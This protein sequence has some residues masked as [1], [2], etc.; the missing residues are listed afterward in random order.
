MSAAGRQAMGPQVLR[1]HAVADTAALQQAAYRWIVDASAH[2]I[3]ARGSFLIVLA[4]GNTPRGVYAM[5]RD[6]T[7][8][9]SCWDVWFGDERCA[10]PDDP[11]RNSVM[12]RDTWLAH[13]AIP[14]DRIH[15]IPSEMGAEPASAAYS[16][17][18]RGIGEFDLVLLGLG[19][20]GHTASL[21]PDHDWGC[22]TDA[23][24]VLAILDASK[25]P[26]QRVSLSA[27]RLS[28]ACEVLFLVDGESK[29]DAVTR[30][31]AGAGIPASAIRPMGGVDALTEASLLA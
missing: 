8:D 9:W 4:G 15:A 19:E 29:R 11:E 20:D 25:P 12:A 13:V 2:A 27:A 31:R 23:P 22:A 24:D 1:W 26:P 6:A 18:L 17:A 10:P 5:L 28:R 21:F 3:A 7:T 16:E 14:H 30:W